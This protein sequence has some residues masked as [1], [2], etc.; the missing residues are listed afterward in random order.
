MD[1][2]V[3]VD[4]DNEFEDYV[5]QWASDA[6]LDQLCVA[7][8]K[9]IPSPR[10]Y[11]GASRGVVQDGLAKMLKESDE[12]RIQL[13]SADSAL[14]DLK[15]RI[16]KTQTTRV[17]VD[18]A[19]RHIENVRLEANT[20]SEIEE[21]IQ[22]LSREIASKRRFYRMVEKD[23]RNDSI[24]MNRI[25]SYEL[26]PYAKVIFSTRS[27][28]LKNTARV[29]AALNHNVALLRKE[30]NELDRSCL[31]PKSQRKVLKCTQF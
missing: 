7:A 28:V 19:I 5:H 3:E 22:L 8:V 26:K 10:R 31:E 16:C 2:K 29:L 20:L 9:T 4:S 17:K 13:F 15:S 18:T 6:T 27:Q 24:H 23:I 1:I 21:A 11:V 14:T 30:K 25:I 12:A